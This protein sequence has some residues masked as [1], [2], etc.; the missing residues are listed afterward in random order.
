MFILLFFMYS[1]P[2]DFQL[3]MPSPF[4]YSIVRGQ[5]SLG[6]GSSGY[7]Q[8]V[9]VPDRKQIFALK[10]VISQKEN[11]ICIVEQDTLNEIIL[12]HSLDHP[13]IVKFESYWMDNI[14][15][16]EH[17]CKVR[18]LVEF[19]DCN[20][21]EFTYYW[22]RDLEITKDNVDIKTIADN[23]PFT[24][25]ESDPRLVSGAINSRS[26]VIYQTATDVLSALAYMHNRGIHHLGIKP[27]NIVLKKGTTTTG[28]PAYTMKLID[29]NLSSDK[30]KIDVQFGF[31]YRYLPLHVL[32]YVIEHEL[33]DKLYKCLHEWFNYV[34]CSYKKQLEEYE[35]KYSNQI[36]M[37]AG[38]NG[39]VNKA[40]AKIKIARRL[41]EPVYIFSDIQNRMKELKAIEFNP[42]LLDLYALGKSLIDIIILF[43]ENK[44]H[45]YQLEQDIQDTLDGL[46]CDEKYKNLIINMMSMNEDLSAEKLLND[47][48]NSE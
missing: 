38:Q 24:L 22:R 21:L 4:K 18:L 13:N 34:E 26:N 17:R 46:T 23:P 16:D 28:M 7:V 33:L 3:K 36:D 37:I 43:D 9:S 15:D 42:K 29:F 6:K 44:L 20:M 45:E 11:G 14:D 12:L 5:L 32:L 27:A 10:T 48:K 19:C 8:K 39:L 31:T 35:E 47:W 40:M 2:T 25:L 1:V 30:A 41:D